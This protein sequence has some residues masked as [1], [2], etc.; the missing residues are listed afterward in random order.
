MAKFYAFGKTIKDSRGNDIIAGI[1]PIKGFELC[2]IAAEKDD[3]SAM[4]LLADLYSDGIGT[5]KNK[6][7]AQKWRTA[8][9]K[10]RR[11]ANDE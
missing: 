5:V 2:K 4:Q 9:A 6:V 8:A 3:I 11:A 1:N 7:T 10:A